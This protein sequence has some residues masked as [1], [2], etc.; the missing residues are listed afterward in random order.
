MN[1]MISTEQLKKMS[2][3]FRKTGRTFQAV[4]IEA[5]ISNIPDH[6]SELT[7]S[8]AK[9]LLKYFGCWLIPPK[10]KQ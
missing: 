2:K 4:A 6:V 1:D 9:Q 7:K 8:E 3:I 5:G 10:D